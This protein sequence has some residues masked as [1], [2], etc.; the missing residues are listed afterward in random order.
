MLSLCLTIRFFSTER[1]KDQNW[2][3]RGVVFDLLNLVLAWWAVCVS[4]TRSGHL[5]GWMTRVCGLQGMRPDWTTAGP[6]K[7]LLKVCDV[8]LLFSYILG[9]WSSNLILE[10]W[11]PAEFSSNLPQHTCL[12]VWSIP[13]K[14]LIS[15][16]RCVLIRVGAKL[17]RDTGPPGPNLV[18]LVLGNKSYLSLLSVVQTV[19]LKKMNIIVYFKL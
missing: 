12:E 13:S 18:T 5:G 8:C 1:C 17:C 11:R 14:T 9:Q 10:G 6:L 19:W 15:C 2:S 7:T 4:A 3:T 16:F